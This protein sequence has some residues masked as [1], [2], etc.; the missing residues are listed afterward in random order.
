MP[1]LAA[2]WVKRCNKGTCY[3]E[4]FGNDDVG[5]CKEASAQEYP[6]TTS[7]TGIHAP[8]CSIAP[9]GSEPLWPTLNST[10]ADPCG[11]SQ[12]EEPSIKAS[13]DSMRVSHCSGRSWILQQ[14]TIQTGF[15]MPECALVE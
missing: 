1:K 2:P 7:T 5:L 6:T 4:F 14:S 8:G 12:N 11:G 3:R 15:A 10:P 9:R 13:T